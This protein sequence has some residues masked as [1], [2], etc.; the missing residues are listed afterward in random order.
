MISNR[1]VVR[2][3]AVCTVTA[4]VFG[5][6]SAG[7]QSATPLGAALC[8]APV[9]A[10]FSQ[11]SPPA[12]T[13][14]LMAEGRFPAPDVA[15]ARALVVMIRDLLNE[16]APVELLASLDVQSRIVPSALT[17][18]DLRNLPNGSRL[19]TAM[20]RRVGDSVVVMWSVRIA[21]RD[22][23][24]NAPMQR[25]T[26]RIDDLPRAALAIAEAA[27]QASVAS[28]QS[29]GTAPLPLG[30]VEAGRAYVLGLAEAQSTEPEALRRSRASLA[31]AAA[32]VPNVADLWRWLARVEYALIDWN[33]D[34]GPNELNGIRVAMLANAT[35]AAQL[36]PRSAGS[37]TLLAMAY[38]LTGAREQ[39][40]IAAAAAVK[41]DAGSP[42]VGRM[43]ASV[44]RMRGDDARALD[45][46]RLAVRLAPR[47]GPLLVELAGLARMRKEAG[48]A[49]YAL[50]A[51]IAADEELAP[52]YA[53]RALV[54]AELGERRSAWADAETATR[55]GHPEWGE[56]AGSVLDAKYGVFSNATVRLRPLGGVRAR[57]TN[58]LDAVFLA[59]AAVAVS[60]SAVV[61][62]LADAWPCTELR[63]AALVRDFRALGIRFTDECEKPTKVGVVAGEYPGTVA[64]AAGRRRAASSDTGTTRKCGTAATR[65]GSPQ[66]RTKTPRDCVSR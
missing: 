33:R 39:A 48:L 20:V 17:P 22:T 34:A 16:R 36:A 60:Q 24:L 65:T 27:S 51:A 38:L 32:L 7:A 41:L 21:G 19:V 50:N 1:A 29:L 46:L 49:C 52:A 5:A 58:Y 44:L 37:Q 3:L 2:R 59:Q 53:M 61:P 54:R 28:F 55:L 66:S 47:D 30:N 12:V 26:T 18:N 4:I 57:P 6:T 11:L 42:E 15:A 56:R 64:E 14:R 8:P 45:Q 10:P 43:T 40:E 9:P 62:Q 13:L 35:R 25:M 31:Q 23:P 63:R